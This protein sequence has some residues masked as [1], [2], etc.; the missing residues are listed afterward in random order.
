MDAI[1]LLQEAFEHVHHA[2]REDLAQVEPD[3]LFWQPEPGL[4]HIGFLYWHLVRDEDTVM[5]YL[6][7]EDELW[8]SEGW[9]ARFGMDAKEQGTG[10][11]S[12]RLAAFRYDLTDFD[13]Y[14]DRIWSRTG[15]ILGRVTEEELDAPA[16]PG[17]GWN[18]AQQI[19]EGTICHDW[20]HLG[21][22]RY[23]MGLRGWRFRE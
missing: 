2:V 4:N 9:H 20:V 13:R 19:V 15:P 22:V 6:A 17:S 21:E 5:S 11:D 18:T 12:G 7:K 16:W 8:R 3:W 10:M 14:R 1:R 23:I